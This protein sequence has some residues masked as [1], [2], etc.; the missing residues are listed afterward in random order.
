MI[1]IMA[2]VFATAAFGLGGARSS[3]RDDRR[4]VDLATISSELEK[5]R[6]DCGRYPTE[7]QYGA[8]PVGESLAGDGS[9]PT[10]TSGSVYIVE[11]LDD[12]ERPARVYSYNVDVAGASYTICTS[13]EG[14]SGPIPVGCTGSCGQACNYAI[15]SP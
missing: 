3:A 1:M 8:V 4:K 9:T 5:Y 13:L 2:I 7:S 12:P 11:K 6:A 10:C 14:E 15:T